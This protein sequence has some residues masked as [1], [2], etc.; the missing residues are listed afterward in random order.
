MQPRILCI[1]SAS[2]LCSVA[3]CGFQKDIQLVSLPEEKHTEV[4]LG[5]I[6]ELMRE[7]GAEFANLDAVAFGAGP[8]AFTGLRVACG[9]AQGLGW[10]LE[11]PLVAVRNL[12]AMAAAALKDAETGTKVFVA[13]DARMN[14]CYCAAFEKTSDG[15]VCTVKEHLLKPETIAAAIKEHAGGFCCGNA[16]TVYPE[17]RADDLRIAE[18]IEVADATM[19][20]PLACKAFAEKRTVSAETAAP[21]YVRNNVA[22]T[23]EERK[24]KGFKA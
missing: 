7:A 1:D 21:L 13:V 24:L 10:A 22:M 8:G 4:I 6:S 17:A 12:E 2:T 19:L 9:T 18:G 14:E 3:V 5:M 11:K 15:V 16:F 23:I 20:M